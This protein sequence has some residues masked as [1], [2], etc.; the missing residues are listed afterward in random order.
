MASLTGLGSVTSEEVHG[1]DVTGQ[2]VDLGAQIENLQ[3]EEQ[4]VRLILSKAQAI[5]DI[6]TIQNQ[7]FSL[8]GQIQQLTGQRD[9]LD[10]QVAYASLS[11]ELT[12]AGTAPVAPPT[13]H[14]SAVARAWSLAG[15]HIVDVARG[16]VLAVGWLSPVLIIGAL[17]GVPLLLRWRK[18]QP[19]HRERIDP[20]QGAEPAPTG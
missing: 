10:V 12:E 2:V 19:S 1:T 6:L 16:F 8:Q 4:A 13:P 17:A 3:S 15:R 14:R 20:P 9:G 5:G 11:V 7:L 18:R